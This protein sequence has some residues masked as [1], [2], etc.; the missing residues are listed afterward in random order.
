M[1]DKHSLTSAVKLLSFVDKVGYE[2]LETFTLTRERE[3]IINDIDEDETY[4]ERLV[5]LSSA[6]WMGYDYFKMWLGDENIKYPNIEI[7]HINKLDLNDFDNGVYY[8]TFN[9][10]ESHYWVWII[11]SDK[12]WY[13]GTYG[14]IPNVTVKQFNK[15]D[16]NKQWLR[17]MEGSLEDYE[18]VFQIKAAVY[19]VG[20]QSIEY[21]KSYKYY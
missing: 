4:E 12:I 6:C 1:D 7:T 2:G 13:A 5:T 9:G 20:F 3:D 8:M 14:G 15:R 19:A 18:Y 10:Y 17:A 11:S 16:Y 21:S